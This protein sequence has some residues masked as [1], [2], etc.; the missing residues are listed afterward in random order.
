MDILQ[1]LISTYEISLFQNKKVI[2]TLCKLFD[3]LSAIDQQ[4]NL[5]NIT[6]NLVLTLTN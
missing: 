6:Y 4:S 2:H 5:K 1:T 3:K